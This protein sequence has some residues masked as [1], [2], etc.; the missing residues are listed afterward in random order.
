MYFDI[1]CLRMGK[2]KPIFNS[3]FSFPFQ[4]WWTHNLFE[5]FLS[6]CQN[7]IVICLFSSEIAFIH[8]FMRQN[9]FV[10]FIVIFLPF[11]GSNWQY[12]RT[13]ENRQVTV[14]QSAL[15]GKWSKKCVSVVTFN[16]EKY[17]RRK[18]VQS[19][20]KKRDRKGEKEFFGKIS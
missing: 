20:I 8:E 12:I 5:S 6:N 15:N 9:E 14:L 19:K 1:E 18:S 17:I 13:L 7:L 2:E 4:L 11:D 16:R 3:Y 10:I